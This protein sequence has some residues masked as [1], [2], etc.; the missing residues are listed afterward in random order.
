MERPR[1]AALLGTLLYAGVF[2]TLKFSFYSPTYIDYQTQT[3]LLA[4]L[5]LM[6][7]QTYG[8]IP[9]LL[10]VGVLQKETLLLLGPVVY[11][12][13]ARTHGWGSKRSLL[14]LTALLLLPFLAHQAVQSAISAINRYSAVDTYLENLVDQTTWLGFWPRFLL[15]ICSGLGL[16]PCLV[17]YR[18]REAAHFLRRQPEW[19]WQIGIGVVLLFGGIDKARLFLFMLP[20]L[21]V[22]AAYLLDQL[23]LLTSVS[24]RAWI[25]ITVLLHLY[26]GHYLTP[27]GTF[28]RY[29]AR[30]VPIHAT[31]S[32]VPTLLEYGTILLIWASLTAL[33]ARGKQPAAELA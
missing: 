4:A 13:Y 16:L 33:L 32:V 27:M 24:G 31:T 20:A 12:H 5:Y 22:V 30:M 14:Y 3:F 21:I 8:P 15:E 10:A 25:A 19:A 26:I 7:R 17:L 18:A 2:W 23:Q 1:Y 28:A 29:L 11:V 6:V 9:I